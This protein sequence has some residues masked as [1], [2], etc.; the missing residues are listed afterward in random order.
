MG[1]R[2]GRRKRLRRRDGVS[3]HPHHRGLRGDDLPFEIRIRQHRR[4]AA[5]VRRHRDA[6]AGRAGQRQYSDPQ[7][8]EQPATVAPASRHRPR[9][10]R[11]HMAGPQA[12]GTQHS[13]PPARS[14][15][16]LPT[17]PL[18]DAE[19]RKS[20]ERFART[21]FPTETAD[22]AARFEHPRNAP[23]TRLLS[24]RHY[25]HGVMAPMRIDI[26][27]STTG[28]ITRL[29]TKALPGTRHALEATTVPIPPSQLRLPNLSPCPR[30]GRRTPMPATNSSAPHIQGHTEWV[31]PPP[32]QPP[33]GPA[34]TAQRRLPRGGR[35][36]ARGGVSRPAGAEQRPPR[37]ST[38]SRTGFLA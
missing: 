13:Q 20:A 34:A 11:G 28:R 7:T 25:D 3:R 6:T 5:V 14:R 8:G 32:A 19:L 33:A 27:V 17:A 10:R 36:T 16:P 18:P 1:P 21:W 24:Y 38:E 26:V 15:R 35:T 22:A 37:P 31:P 30:N 12:H 4:D 2:H 9:I 23:D 29:T